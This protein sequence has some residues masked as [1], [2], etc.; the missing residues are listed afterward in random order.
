MDI[1]TLLTSCLEAFCLLLHLGQYH[2]DSSTNISTLWKFLIQSLQWIQFKLE[3]QML[4]FRIGE[5]ERMNLILF[6]R[7]R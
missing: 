7:G 2:L 5:W 1:Y 3:Y 4:E 6:A